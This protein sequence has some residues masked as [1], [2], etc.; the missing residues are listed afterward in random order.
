MSTGL[1]VL[2]GVSLLLTAQS[3]YSTVLMLYAWEAAGRGERNRVPEHFEPPC[4]SVGSRCHP[5]GN[6]SPH[7]HDHLRSAVATRLNRLAAWEGM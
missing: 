4:A 5:G 7:L 6:R 2:V 1:L 3:A